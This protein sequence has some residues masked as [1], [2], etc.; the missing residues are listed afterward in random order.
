[1]SVTVPFEF[2]SADDNTTFSPEFKEEVTSAG[3]SEATL[4]FCAFV[5][6]I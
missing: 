6:P 1:M 4:V 3:F 2:T 5:V